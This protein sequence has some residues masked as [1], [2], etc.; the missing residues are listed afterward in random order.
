MKYWTRAV[1]RPLNFAPDMNDT[2]DPRSGAEFLWKFEIEKATV[3]KDEGS[4]SDDSNNSDGGVLLPKYFPEELLEHYGETYP[5]S[6]ESKSSGGFLED[7]IA[8]SSED[9]QVFN[10]AKKDGNAK[11]MESDLVDDGYR[12]P[13]QEDDSQIFSSAFR[14]RIIANGKAKQMKS[15]LANAKSKATSKIDDADASEEE[16]K[17][18]VTIDSPRTLKRK[19]EEKANK[20]KKASKKV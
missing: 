20:A 15:D 4:G 14:E 17:Q 12:T 16:N 19:A 9:G 8:N 7:G 2:S 5:R 6:K 10:S 1:K 3:V 11:R 18:S 13:D